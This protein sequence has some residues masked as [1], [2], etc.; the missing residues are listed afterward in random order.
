MTDLG[1]IDFNRYKMADKI[2]KRALL[3]NNECLTDAKVIA[4]VNEAVDVL[5]KRMPFKIT[6]DRDADDKEN[7]TI[8]AIVDK[9]GNDVVDG[10]LEIHIQSLGVDERYWLD[11]GE[12]DF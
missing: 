2:R 11:S 3:E 6:I 5:K 12:F 10:N 4:L 8:T 9:N 1:S 7:L